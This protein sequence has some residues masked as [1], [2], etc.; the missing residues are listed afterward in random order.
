M[1]LIKTLDRVDIRGRGRGGRK[2]ARTR[3][4]GN[5]SGPVAERMAGCP[6]SQGGRPSN[7]S[8]TEEGAGQMKASVLFGAGWENDSLGH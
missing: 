2:G 3:P 8:R 4:V 7:A 5:G 6:S 1:D